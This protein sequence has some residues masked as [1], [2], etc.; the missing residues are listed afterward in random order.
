M[1]KIIGLT[2][3]LKTDYQPKETDPADI[4]AEFDHPHTIDLIAQTIADDK[5]IINV[6]TNGSQERCFFNRNTLKTLLRSF[7][8]IVPRFTIAWDDDKKAV[9]NCTHE[10]GY[11]KLFA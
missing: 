1:G 10:Q 6:A 3:D 8:D 2:Y 7:K 4:N 5:D 11:V 9:L